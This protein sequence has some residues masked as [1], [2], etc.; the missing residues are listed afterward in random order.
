MTSDRKLEAKAAREAKRKELENSKAVKVL[1]WIII[2]V[3]FLAIA[4]SCIGGDDGDD[5]AADE[6]AAKVVPKTP[7]GKLQAAVADAGVKGAKVIGYSDEP[8]DTADGETIKV[9]QVQFQ[10]GDGFSNN[11]IRNGIGMDTFDIAEAAVKSKVPFDELWVSGT[12]DMQD[13]YG[14]ELPN[15][16]VYQAAF[17]RSE[18]AKINYDNVLTDFDRVEVFTIDNFVF[19]HPAFRGE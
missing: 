5:K 12:F 19:L 17:L 3:V 2:G 4:G 13:K 16:K 18:L 11:S 7:K 10:I 1:S 9:A 14:K 6:P 8:S 15:Q